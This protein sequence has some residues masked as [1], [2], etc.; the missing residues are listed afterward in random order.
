MCSINVHHQCEFKLVG[1]GGGGELMS[2]PDDVSC[3]SPD[4]GSFPDDGVCYDQDSTSAK[5]K[6]DG[7]P[8]VPSEALVFAL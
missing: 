2:F 7:R 8:L 5:L 1:M 6:F 4:R 3:V